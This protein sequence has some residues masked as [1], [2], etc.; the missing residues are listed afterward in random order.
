MK[1]EIRFKESQKF[2]QWWLWLI[3]LA[4]MLLFVISTVITYVRLFTAQ[5]PNDSG[6][7]SM[8]WI[9]NKISFAELLPY[10]LYVLTVLFF[11]FTKLKVVVTNNEICIRHLIFFKK[12]ISLTE[13]EESRITDYGFVGYGIRIARKY[14]T[15]YNVKGNQGVALTLKNGKRY[16][17]GSQKAK[18]LLQAISKK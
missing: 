8:M 2:T 3:I 10:F 18:E 15:V 6:N 4:P 16:L 17:I 1:R 11:A 5:I 12:K 14:G 9:S 13:I 7:V